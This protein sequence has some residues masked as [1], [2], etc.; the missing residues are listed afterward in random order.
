MKL[1]LSIDEQAWL[2]EVVAAP[3]FRLT[4]TIQRSWRELRL[5]AAARLTLAALPSELR[6]EILD[7]WLDGHTDTSFFYARSAR[8]L[9]YILDRIRDQPH[10]ASICRFERAV[11]TC[12]AAATTFTPETRSVNELPAGTKVA[13]H[14]AAS[15]V[16]F[17][18][19]P[20]TIFA[21]LLAGADMPV[22]APEEERFSLL[23]APGLFKLCRRAT[24][25]ELA[26]WDQCNSPLGLGRL[27]ASDIR[28]ESVVA[29]L[30][31]AG[32]FSLTSDMAG[33]KQPSRP[34]RGT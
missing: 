28:L 14:P 17:E 21:S 23:V 31:A 32:V 19:D 15:V 22:P 30:L 34:R 1:D 8:L 13:H 4:C 2:D 9:D 27:C 24:A 29:E 18:A 6:A 12:S 16:E 3:G 7:G 25:V 20:E 5:K 33:A 26:L 10:L 11:L